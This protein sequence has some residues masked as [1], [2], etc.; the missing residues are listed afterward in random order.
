MSTQK[1]KLET[2][3]VLPQPI[4]EENKEALD[5]YKETT[6][7]LKETYKVL[8]ETD[9]ALGRKKVYTYMPCSTENIEINH[10]KISLTTDSYKI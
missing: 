10:D 7:I 5:L 9:I 8:E 2:E 1:T 3:K 4:L 6:E